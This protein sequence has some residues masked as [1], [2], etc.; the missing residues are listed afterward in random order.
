MRREPRR[1]RRQANMSQLYLYNPISNLKTKTNYELLKGITGKSKDNLHSFKHK[2]RKIK[3]LNCY[4]IDETFNKADL[5]KL[6]CKE[7][8]EDEIWKDVE[9]SNGRY[10]ISSYGRAARVYKDGRK[11]LLMPYIRR[12][13]WLHVKVTINGKVKEI[14][15]HKLVATHFIENPNRYPVSYHKDENIYNNYADNLGWIDHVTLGKITAHKAKAVPVLKIDPQSGEVLDEYISMAEA[16]R[17][18]FVHRETIRQCVTGR[19][20]TAG[21]FKWEIVNYAGNTAG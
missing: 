4:I 20:K 5:Y 14:A 11:R 9:G 15:V 1:R 17:F 18:N 8:P 13:K 16:G 2:K 3:S 12:A 6:M 21:G 19:L 7:K 10:Q